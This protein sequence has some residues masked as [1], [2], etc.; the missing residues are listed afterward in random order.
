V[1]ATGS[2][3]PDLS[4]F[5][6]GHE[7]RWNRWRSSDT[8]LRSIAH[9]EGQGESSVFDGTREHPYVTLVGSSG[10]TMSREKAARLRLLRTVTGAV[11]ILVTADAGRWLGAAPIVS[12]ISLHGF[13]VGLLPPSIVSLGGLVLSF[14]IQLRAA[15]TVHNNTRRSNADVRA[16]AKTFL[17]WRVCHA[18][19]LHT[20]FEVQILTGH[21]VQERHAMPSARHRRQP[22]RSFLWQYQQD[23]VS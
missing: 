8:S 15:V 11:T 7:R 4:S 19:M 14:R 6:S 9:P 17:C 16:N 13:P 22:L 3:L 20:T 2:D 21:F 10:Q 23:R 12:A 1:V 5:V 18:P